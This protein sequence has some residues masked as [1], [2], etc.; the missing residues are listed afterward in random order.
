MGSGAFLV[1]AARVLALALARARAATGDGRVTPDLVQRS[2]RDVIRHCLYGV[3]LNPLAVVL[4]KVSLWLETLERGKPLTFLD[5]HLRLG[6]SLIGVNFTGE[7]GRL[8]TDELG[9]WPKVAHKGL[10]TY[11]KKEAG[12]LGEPVLEQLKKRKGLGAKKQESLPGIGAAALEEALAEIAESREAIVGNG[13]ESLQLELE[14]ARKFAQ[15]EER[16]DSLR[17]RLLRCGRLLVRAMV[18]GW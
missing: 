1:Q 14:H 18:R 2:K 4:A 9:H 3:D 12:P 13:E 16:K 15:L 6:D 11:L 7:L 8:S 10:E 5:A 17:N